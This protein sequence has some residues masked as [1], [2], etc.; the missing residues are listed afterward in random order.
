LAII[1]RAVREQLEHDRIIRLLQEKFRRHFDV[2]VNVGDERGATFKMGTATYYPDLILT[3]RQAPRRVVAVFEI[4]T[5]ESV[6][7]LEAMAQ[8]ANF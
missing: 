4:E 1:F 5:A 6:N 8:W 2:D 7:H 3:S